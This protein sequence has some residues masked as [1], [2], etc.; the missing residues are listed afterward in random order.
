MR[1]NFRLP[2]DA[3]PCGF[4]FRTMCSGRVFSPWN[5]QI[6]PTAFDIA[7]TVSD[8]I[9]RHYGEDEDLAEPVISRL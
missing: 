1:L 3:P 9:D 5:G 6:I 4:S 2:D 7:S 8:A